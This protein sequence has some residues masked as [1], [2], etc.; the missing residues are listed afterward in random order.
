MPGPLSIKESGGGE[1]FCFGGNGLS[2]I[3]NDGR[4]AIRKKQPMI[5]AAYRKYFFSK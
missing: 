4:S 3:I 5:I 1:K 2:G